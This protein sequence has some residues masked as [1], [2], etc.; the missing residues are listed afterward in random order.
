MLDVSGI[1]VSVVEVDMSYKCSKCKKQIKKKIPQTKILKYRKIKL[2][3]GRTRKQIISEEKV[4]FNCSKK[5]E[6]KEVKK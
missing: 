5:A 2:R 4:C 1:S 6:D 3:D